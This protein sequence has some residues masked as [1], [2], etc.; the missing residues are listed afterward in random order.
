MPSALAVI[1]IDAVNPRRV[2]DFWCD[3]FGW[4][5]LEADPD[6]VSIG[7]A[8]GHWPTIDVCRVPDAKTVKNR[9]HLDVRA[10]G[11]ERAAELQRLLDLGAKRVDVGQP[12][13]ASWVV[14]ADVEGNEFCLLART[15]QDVARG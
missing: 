9:L 1:A 12:S 14:L 8:D 15:V 6:I 5:V 13:D 2:A 3:V 4:V 7:P 10:D 11:L